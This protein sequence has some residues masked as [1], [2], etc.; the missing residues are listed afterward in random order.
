MVISDPSYNHEY[1]PM[2]GDRAFTTAALKLILGPDSPP[3]LEN[4]V[5]FIFNIK[6]KK[7]YINQHRIS[8]FISI[9]K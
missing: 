7:K 1:L 9:Y 8:L 4:R 3:L 2:L 6:E 5:K